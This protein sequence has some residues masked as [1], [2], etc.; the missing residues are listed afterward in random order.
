MTQAQNYSSQQFSLSTTPGWIKSLGEL[1]PKLGLALVLGGLALAA[2]PVAAYIQTRSI[3][4]PWFFWGFFL[5]GWT[6][7]CGALHLANLATLKSSDAVRFLLVALGGGI[8]IATTILGMSLPFLSYSEVFG[9][10][11]VEW[12]KHPR[13]LLV[14][15]S[16]L[17]GGILIAFLSL[18][19]AKGSERESIT[20]RR[21]LYGANTLITALLLFA[22]LGLV[23]VL[24]FVNLGRFDFFNTTFDYTESSLYTLSSGTKDLLQSLEEPILV[25]MMIPES[26]LIG[27]ESKTLLDNCKSVAPKDRFSWESVSRDRDQSGLNK[28]IEKFQIPDALG[29]LV[30]YGSEGGKQQHD[31]IAY[32]KLYSTPQR[33]MNPAEESSSN[34]SYLGEDVLRKSIITLKEGKNE[35]KVYITSG[36]GELSL[37]DTTGSSVDGVGMIA[38]QLNKANYK[39]EDLPF[40]AK[41]KSIPIDAELVIMA[42]PKSDPAPEAINA[43]R[44]Y[45]TREVGGKKGKAIILLDTEKTRQGSKISWTPMPNLKA[46]L[47]EFQV[48][49]GDNQL[50]NARLRPATTVF[51]KANETSRNKVAMA[52]NQSMIINF[53]MESARTVS[54]I[55]QQPGAPQQKGFQVEDVI[56][57][58]SGQLRVFTENDPSIDPNDLV[59]D[60]LGKPEEL[61]KRLSQPSY[62]VGVFV[63]DT[64]TG[65]ENIPG[66][67]RMSTDAKPRLAVFGDATWIS[68]KMFSSQFG[69][70]NYNLFYSTLSWLKDRPDVGEKPKGS[71]RKTYRLTMTPDSPEFARLK[72]MPLW[73]MLASVGILGGA[74]WV[75]R[76]R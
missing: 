73:L 70:N 1:G 32:D 76:R 50:L 23:N 53:V 65:V 2:I 38:E 51:A 27:G 47:S 24:S 33:S 18:I 10:G 36:N 30:V 74:V 11:L 45:L 71:E 28:L 39:T 64:G 8:G 68:N 75:V 48:Q 31:F 5:S 37:T 25:Y 44:E 40:D 56:R 9:G 59:R 7:F 12:R 60:L 35:S 72:W 21:I 16:L 43:L 67:E 20:M 66:H 55:P 49:V 34:F 46:L 19:A 29:M 52:F 42:R 14:T 54:P 3:Q 26:T 61:V 15:L 69:E 58:P 63:S 4:N 41:L 6:L 22:I 62:P 17:L 57:V 13:E